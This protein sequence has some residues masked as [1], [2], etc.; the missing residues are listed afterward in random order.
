MCSGTGRQ[1]Q[2]GA[3]GTGNL[4]DPLPPVGADERGDRPGVTVAVEPDEATVREIQQRRR[5]GPSRHLT[6][7]REVGLHRSESGVRSL[8]I[9]RRNDHHR[10]RR[11]GLTTAEHP[12]DTG[13]EHDQGREDQCNHGAQGSAEDGVEVLR[14]RR[15]GAIR[16]GRRQ[17]G[18]ERHTRHRGQRPGGHDARPGTALG[19]GAG[20]TVVYSA[21]GGQW[22][23]GE[24]DAGLRPRDGHPPAV[25]HHPPEEAGVGAG[26]A[27]ARRCQHTVHPGR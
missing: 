10:L 16:C 25:G 17:V 24:F 27:P 4:V 21:G 12:R 2:F 7:R 15:G 1:P 8:R 20:C 11:C 6:V 26:G 14:P 9:R 5:K 13:A 18:A 3:H 22:F 23:S 19:D